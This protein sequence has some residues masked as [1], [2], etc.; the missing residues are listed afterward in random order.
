MVGKTVRVLCEGTSK[1]DAE[2]MTGRTEGGKIVNFNGEA[3]HIGT[4]VD[5]KITE[6]KTWNLQGEAICR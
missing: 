2:K 4:F 3:S 5:V 1:T 6:A